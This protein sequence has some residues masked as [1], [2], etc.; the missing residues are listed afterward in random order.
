MIEPE[1]EKPLNKKH[2]LNDEEVARQMA[3]DW[4]V[5]DLE[6]ERLRGNRKK[7]QV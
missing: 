5:K 4:N 3:E 2:A 6:V 1:V 7:R